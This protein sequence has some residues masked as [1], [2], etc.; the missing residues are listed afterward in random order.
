MTACRRLSSLI[1]EQPIN[2][3]CSTLLQVWTRA[4]SAMPPAILVRNVSLPS[5]ITLRLNFG[6]CETEEPIPLGWLSA[7]QLVAVHANLSPSHPLRTLVIYAF[8]QEFNL[9]HR[10][11]S[12]AL[13]TEKHSTREA[14]A[15]LKKTQSTLEH[16]QVFF[17][18]S[19]VGYDPVPA[20][21]PF[22]ASLQ[23]LSVSDAEFGLAGSRY[24][25]LT[26]LHLKSQICG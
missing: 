15:C 26:D 20:F 13:R 10:T 4:P 22:K 12:I 1:I 6:W 21:E 11:A 18:L 16:I 9:E 14:I 7:S 24:P 25:R 19:D 5:S 23:E 3:P 17:H 2:L 8:H